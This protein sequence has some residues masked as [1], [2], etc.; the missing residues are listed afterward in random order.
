VAV[1]EEEV[2]EVEEMEG[3]IGG[4]MSTIRI[5]DKKEESL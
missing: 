1:K 3:T 2:V 4:R 5:K